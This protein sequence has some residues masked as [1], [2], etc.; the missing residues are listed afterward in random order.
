MTGVEGYCRS[1]NRVIAADIIGDGLLKLYQHGQSVLDIYG[2][3]HD[4]NH[5]VG[6][7]TCVTPD[8]PNGEV[9]K[10]AFK[11]RPERACDKVRAG[12]VHRAHEYRVAV[13]YWCTGYEAPW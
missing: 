12:E 2:R 8:I 1:C 10:F 9:K 4:T 11:V 13:T 7:G 5:C 3:A 6:S